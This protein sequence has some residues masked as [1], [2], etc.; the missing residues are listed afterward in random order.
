V[1]RT[2]ELTEIERRADALDRAGVRVDVDLKRAPVG[3]AEVDT[4]GEVRLIWAAERLDN[5]L[6]L[7][8]LDGADHLVVA[9]QFG[10]IRRF[11]RADIRVGQPDDFLADHRQGAGDADDQYK[12]PDGQRQP[13]MYEKPEFGA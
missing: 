2:G 10:V 12:E 3:V 6:G 4:Q 5:H 11:A 13:A 7:G 1:Q 9:Q 8:T